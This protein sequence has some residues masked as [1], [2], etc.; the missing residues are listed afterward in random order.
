MKFATCDCPVGATYH[1]LNCPTSP[2]KP[3]NLPRWMK[4]QLRRERYGVRSDV[5]FPEE[6]TDDGNT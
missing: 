5:V 4:D 3:Q 1:A 6:E 2:G